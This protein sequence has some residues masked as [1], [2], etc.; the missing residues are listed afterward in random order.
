ML[1]RAENR[2]LLFRVRT[3][4]KCAVLPRA[5]NRSLLFRVR[6][7]RI[8]NPGRNNL[9]AQKKP[10]TRIDVMKI[11]IDCELRQ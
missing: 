5:E 1:R 3:A 4:R 9:K 7:A 8:S 10:L 2:S 11:D 6:T